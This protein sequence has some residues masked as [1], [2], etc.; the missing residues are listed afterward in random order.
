MDKFVRQKEKV[1]DF[2]T[3]YSGIR[4]ADIHESKAVPLE[5]VQEEAAKLMKDRTLVGHSIQNDLKVCSIPWLLNIRPCIY[6][7][8]VVAFGFWSECI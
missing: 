4:P 3:K 7:T 2:R 8:P 6:S 5:E 1:T